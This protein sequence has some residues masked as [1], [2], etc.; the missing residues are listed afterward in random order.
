VYSVEGN[1]A[2]GLASCGRGTRA[3]PLGERAARGEYVGRSGQASWVGARRQAKGIC[4]PYVAALVYSG[5][6]AWGTCRRVA[7]SGSHNRWSAGRQPST[8]RG[9]PSRSRNSINF[10]CDPDF[11]PCAIWYSDS[12]SYT[13]SVDLTNTPGGIQGTSS[14]SP[15]CAASR[16]IV[17]RYSRDLSLQL[18]RLVCHSRGRLQRFNGRRSPGCR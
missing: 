5:A 4:W 17:I 16:E 12:V 15:S 7:F 2:I 10:G 11:V 18:N 8:P 1:V 14:S 13:E 9:S 3:H 6:L